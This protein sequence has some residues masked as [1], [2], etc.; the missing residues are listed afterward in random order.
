MV[1]F[2][3][4]SDV[5]RTFEMRTITF[6][7]VFIYLWKI[8]FVFVNRFDK[9]IIDF[10]RSHYMMQFFNLFDRCDHEHVCTASRLQY[11]ILSHERI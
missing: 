10:W 2:S 11:Y 9:I 8:L 3:R 6:G 5:T 4:I 1:N 7:V